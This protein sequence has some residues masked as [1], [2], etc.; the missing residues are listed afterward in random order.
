LHQIDSQVKRQK[1]EKSPV[2][3]EKIKTIKV[4]HVKLRGEEWVGG[5]AYLEE[6]TTGYTMGKP[7]SLLKMDYK[8][9]KNEAPKRNSRLRGQRKKIAA[10]G[11]EDA[12]KEL[13]G[14]RKPR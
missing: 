3:E 9:G 1:D 10:G 2:Q 6:T 13:K 7:S 8:E 14:N 4:L 12:R 5:R 11:G